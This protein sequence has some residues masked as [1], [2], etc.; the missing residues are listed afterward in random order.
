MT[1]YR[2]VARGLVGAQQWTSGI[3]TLLFPYVV[4]EIYRD[5]KL[6]ISLNYSK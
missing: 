1:N 2:A 6:V 5:N 4:K 3:I